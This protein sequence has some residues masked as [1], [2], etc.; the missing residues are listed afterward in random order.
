MRLPNSQP[1]KFIVF[2]DHAQIQLTQ[3]YRL[4]SC[5][6]QWALNHLHKHLIGGVIVTTRVKPNVNRSIEVA[7]KGIEQQAQARASES[8]LRLTLDRFRPWY[9]PQRL[10]GPQRGDRSGCS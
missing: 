10:Q 9:R 7:R 1:P 8:S 4:V 2:V 3:I 5:A 6:I